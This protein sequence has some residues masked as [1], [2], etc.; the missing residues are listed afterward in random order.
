MNDQTRTDVLVSPR[1]SHRIDEAMNILLLEKLNLSAQD[2]RIQCE[3]GEIISNI[4]LLG[5][6][7]SCEKISISAEDVSRMIAA[8]RIRE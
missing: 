4:D 7:I 8:N 1:Q 2:N 5:Q 6:Q 3:T